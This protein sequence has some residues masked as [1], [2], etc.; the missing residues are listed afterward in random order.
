MLS[1][2]EDAASIDVDMSVFTELKDADDSCRGTVPELNAESQRFGALSFLSSS[3]ASW[4]LVLVASWW[5][6]SVMVILLIKS[7]I[8]SGRSPGGFALTGA[9]N[10]CTGLTAWF[11]TLA[12]PCAQQPL[13]LLTWKESFK[14]GL[15]GMIQGAEFACSNKSLEYLSVSARTM[16]SS[17]NV[18]FMMLTARIW[19]LEKLGYMRLTAAALLTAGGALQGIDNL[20][21][22]HDS[23]EGRAFTRGMLLQL[24]AML[25]AAQ[26][27]A[28]VQL[29]IQRSPAGSALA[30][31][32]KSKLQLV[33]RTLPITG[34]VCF[35]LSLYFEREA[36]LG[37]AWL[38]LDLAATTFAIS[39]GI[40]ILTVAELEIVRIASAVAI[41]VLGTLH[42][43]PVALAGI[44]IF[45]ESVRLLSWFGFVL[46]IAGGLCYVTVRFRE[47]RV[48]SSRERLARE[49]DGMP[50]EMA[51][52]GL[53]KA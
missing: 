48:G 19:G 9:A 8:A 27:W 3:V 29:V 39:A 49:L 51:D 36:L 50:V 43:I 17:T 45:G 10:A 35:A 18:L 7:V 25:L 31:M 46:C 44:M 21:G 22:R 33:Q 13:P 47:T 40:V 32:S 15:L 53:L 38:R 41:Q 42:Q 5:S 1:E 52:Q 11:L 26:R 30:H 6:M 23:E 14:L 12:V 37:G 4:M 16:S 2:V 24:V 20:S 34:L 28:L